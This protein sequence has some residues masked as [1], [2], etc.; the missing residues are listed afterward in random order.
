M[1]RRRCWAMG[2]MGFPVPV[3][4]LGLR[5]ECGPKFR[6]RNGS[7]SVHCKL[8]LRSF[9]NC[10]Y[11]PAGAAHSLPLA[12]EARSCHRSL[13]HRGR[14]QRRRRPRHL[15]GGSTATTSP[16]RTP[17]V[18]S[19]GRH[20]SS[21][22]PTISARRRRLTA[23]RRVLSLAPADLDL[24][25]SGAAAPAT[26]RCTGCSWTGPQREART[27]WRRRTAGRHYAARM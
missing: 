12:W 6:S 14:R 18:K 1:D 11:L 2:R 25:R 3:L 26:T 13:Q 27:A 24:D 19:P 20:A 5:E 8:L 7:S 16:S 21:P 4:S 23:P 9:S 15:A 17:T 10:L 22:S